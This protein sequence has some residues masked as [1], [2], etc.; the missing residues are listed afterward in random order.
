MAEAHQ[1]RPLCWPSYRLLGSA[2]Q[3]TDLAAESTSHSKGNRPDL[4]HPCRTFPVNYPPP[5]F[6][7]NS[8]E[9]LR[10]PGS[11]LPS[12]KRCSPIKEKD[13]RNV[14]MRRT[15]ARN[16]KIWGLAES[17]IISRM[18]EMEEKPQIYKRWNS[19][20]PQTKFNTSC[21]ARV[22]AGF[23]KPPNRN[24]NTDIF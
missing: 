3:K 8:K 5:P 11:S 23:R 1:S 17:H 6:L 12:R 18:Q 16:G 9:N 4:P 24:K 7:K 13:G 19:I 15:G 14:R 2:P 21:D 10:H 20:T 22:S